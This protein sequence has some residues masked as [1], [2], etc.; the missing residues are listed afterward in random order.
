MTL[1]VWRICW[2]ERDNDNYDVTRYDDELYETEE[3]AQ[4]VADEYNTSKATFVKD[5][6]FRH[7]HAAWTREV[8]EFDALVNAGLRKRAH[9][10]TE[11]VF[12]PLEWE[13]WDSYSSRREVEEVE[14]ICTSRET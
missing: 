14:V 8:T 5:N 2:V 11:P 7:T 13:K 6:I 3:Q 9:R 10:P 4:T 12:N 1:S